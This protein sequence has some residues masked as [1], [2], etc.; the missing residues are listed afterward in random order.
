[1]TYEIRILPFFQLVEKEKKENKQ[2]CFFFLQLGKVK[3]NR[4]KGIS[5]HSL[6]LVC[7]A[8]C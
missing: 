1:M 3:K 6:F 8:N 7:Q 5:S 4:L 2:Y